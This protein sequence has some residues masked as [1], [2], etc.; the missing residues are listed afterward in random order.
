MS[1]LSNPKTQAVCIA[2]DPIK[3]QYQARNAFESSGFLSRLLLESVSSSHIIVV[4]QL[5]A[6]ARPLM[7]AGVQI[8]AKG[9]FYNSYGWQQDNMS[10][11]SSCVVIRY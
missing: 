11:S 9:I 6:A 8:F 7:N 2:Q 1:N 4:S 10:S 5:M 3:I